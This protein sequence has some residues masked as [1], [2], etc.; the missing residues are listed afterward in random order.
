[1]YKEINKHVS[2]KEGV[3]YWV[4]DNG[5]KREMPKV[6]IRKELAEKAHIATNHR[7]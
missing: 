1:M 5:R 7:K 3:E 4:N 6:E 2:L